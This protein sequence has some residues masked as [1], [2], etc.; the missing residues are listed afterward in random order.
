MEVPLPAPI[1]FSTPAAPATLAATNISHQIAGRTVLQDVSAA[2]GP[3]ARLGVVGPNGVGK[4]TLL[5]ILAGLDEPSSGRVQVAPPTATVGYL[6]QEPARSAHETVRHE[7]ARTTGVLAAEEGLHSAADALARGDERSEERYSNALER[8]QELGAADFGPRS[9]AVL[10]AFGLPAGI[11]ELPTAALSG[12]QAA[13][14]ALA[15]VLLSRY[16]VTLLDEPTNN[17]D[18]DGLARLERFVATRPGGV[19]I[20]SHDR[21]FLEATITSVLELDEHDHTARLFNGGWSAYLEER[22]VARRHAAE[23]YLTYEGRRQG[24]QDRAQRE[25]QWATKGTRR[26]KRGARD[27][28][29]VQRDF[30]VNRTEQLAARAKR[31][32][33]AIARL[34]EVEKPWESWD[35]RF[36]IGEAPR[37]GAVVARLEK[38]VVT[39]GSFELGPLDLEMGVDLLE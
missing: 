23:A 24:L 10:R 36:S 25:R 35:L 14:V 39:R 13:T 20:V 33:R 31:T 34:R 4:S 29:K 2:V 22:A 16:Q 19:V 3:G 7:L 37:S 17:L 18:F 8:W 1:A 12:G 26:E 27:N 6:A 38:A 32:D 11:L 21:A 9:E 5:R 28:D 15:G 30:R